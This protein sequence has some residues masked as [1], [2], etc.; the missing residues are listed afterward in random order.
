MPTDPSR[1]CG[2]CGKMNFPQIAGNAFSTPLHRSMPISR[3]PLA[4]STERK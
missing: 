4:P 1:D 2:K 3:L